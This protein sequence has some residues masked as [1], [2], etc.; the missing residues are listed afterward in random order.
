MSCQ[1]KLG[2]S[3]GYSARCCVTWE[4]YLTSLSLDFLLSIVGI[5]PKEGGAVGRTKENEQRGLSTVPGSV[6]SSFYYRQQK[7]FI[8]FACYLT[9]YFLIFLLVQILGYKVSILTCLFAILFILSLFFNLLNSSDRQPMVNTSM[10]IS[11]RKKEIGSLHNG[12]KH[13]RLHIFLLRN[14]KLG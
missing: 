1:T 9:F 11:K 14:G 8:S 5:I 10:C 12:L 13:C 3:I 6:Q 2:F 7:S 4:S